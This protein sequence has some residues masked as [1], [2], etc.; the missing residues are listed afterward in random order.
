MPGT[1]PADL[2]TADVCGPATAG[3]A[4]KANATRTPTAE[5][6]LTERFTAYPLVL[7]LEFRVPLGETAVNRLAR[8]ETSRKATSMRKVVAYELMSLDGVAESPET[9]MSWDDAMDA[10][11]ADVIS[12]QDTVILGRLMYDEWARY[13]PPSDIEPFA[14]FIN[15]VQKFIATSTPLDGGWDNAS[16]IEGDLAD[17]VRTLKTRPGRDIGVH[18]SITTTQSL[19]AAGVIDELRLVIAPAV[20][21]T[22][23]RLFDG[24]APLTFELQSSA[25]SPTGAVMLA[26]RVLN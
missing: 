22:G 24:L 25:T 21:G 15:S 20:T 7:R 8:P 11:L 1:V 5:S 6:N 19:L 4:I 2:V 14:S 3:W 23:R 17:F 26:Y 10:N 13:W 9:F 16:A 18:G 12:T